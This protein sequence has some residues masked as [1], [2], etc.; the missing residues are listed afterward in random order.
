MSVIF[1]IELHV[2]DLVGQVNAKRIQ[3]QGLL[4]TSCQWKWCYSGNV[5]AA[6]VLLGA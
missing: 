2:R 3:A 1:F 4:Q 6:C 5:L